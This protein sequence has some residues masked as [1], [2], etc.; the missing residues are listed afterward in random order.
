MVVNHHA[1][2][3]IFSTPSLHTGYSVV[4]LIAVVPTLFP[5]KSK[6]CSKKKQI[7]LY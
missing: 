6:L 2:Q 5:K 7:T 3:H 4:Y 1:L